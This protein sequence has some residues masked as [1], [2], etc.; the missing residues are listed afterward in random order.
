MRHAIACTTC[1]LSLVL[2]ACVPPNDD[3]HPVARALPRAEDVRIDLPDTGSAKGTSAAVGDLSPWYVVTRAVTHGLNSGTAW[4]LIVVHAIVQYPPTT[5]EDDRWTWGP[6]GGDRP[7]EPAEYRLVVTELANGSYDWNLDGRSKRDPSA[8]FE[9]VISGNAIP[10]PTDGTGHGDFTID[11]DA[12]ERVNPI[13]NHARG[14]VGVYYDLAARHLE[15]AIATVEDRDGV[16]TPVEL[17][18]RY[19]EAADGSG[20]MVFAVHADTDDAGPA[21]EDAIIRSRWLAT[22]EGRADVRLSGGDLGDLSVTASECWDGTFGVVYY[23]DSVSFLPT[24]GVE[25]A[26]A[27]TTSDLPPL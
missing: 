15:M 4:V 24:D 6:W 2:V 22:G 17:D 5:V 19:D 8:G 21:A 11:F 12:A 18:Y 14:V 16:L 23:R 27:F 9:T 7:L 3:P 20:N 25:A 10:G 26:C 13:D 1:A